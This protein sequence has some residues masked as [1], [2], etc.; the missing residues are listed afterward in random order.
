MTSSMTTRGRKTPR[1][2][3]SR[4]TVGVLL[5]AT[6]LLLIEDG[7]ARATTNRIAERAG[8]S[9]GSLYQYFPNRE[10]LVT[11]LA[12]RTETDISRT[13][14]L[15]LSKADQRDLRG[16]MNFG[17]HTMVDSHARVLPLQRILIDMML[18]SAVVPPPAD[19]FFTWQTMLRN[20]F[21]IHASELR[22][23]FD[24]EAGCFFIPRMVG[25]AIDAAIVSRPSAFANGELERE[26][27]S[28]LLNYLI[29]QR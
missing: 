1:Q 29:G 13:I 8:V 28:M 11:A 27:S 2:A 24:A 17:L 21:T 5:D 19:V 25:S 26:L 20:I 3:R 14:M 10:A 7:D 16:I 22:S 23:G 4:A 9:I 6:A 12:H 18:H 15:A